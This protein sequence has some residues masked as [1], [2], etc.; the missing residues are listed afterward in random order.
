MGLSAG[1]ARLL[2]ITAR[3]SDCEYQS[4]QFSHQK[5]A[6]SRQL[7]DVSN[8][9]QN[10]L[11]QTKLVYDFYGTG[12]SNTPLS[13]GILMTPS[14]LN[15]YMPNLVTNSSGRVILNN[16]YA[17]AAEAAG[18]PKEG[19]G[20]TPSDTVRNMFLQGLYDAGLITRQRLDK[21]SKTAYNQLAGLGAVSSVTIN[22]QEVS[23]EELTDLLDLQGFVDPLDTVF[24][25]EITRGIGL[26]NGYN[27]LIS[28][29]MS[30][31]DD[32]LFGDAT[33]ENVTLGDI[34]NGNYYLVASG[35]DERNANLIDPGSAV[36]AIANSA[37]WDIMLESFESILDT[38][39][40]YTQDAL[41]YARQ[42]IEFLI[43]NQADPT[44]YTGDKRALLNQINNG[45]V[46]NFVAVTG[47]AD[48]AY[49][50][51]VR[52]KAKNFAD[53]DKDGYIG[54][55]LRFNCGRGSDDDSDISCVSM[56]LSSMMKAY[57]T[58]FTQKMQGLANSPYYVGTQLETS[59]LVDESTLYT[60]NA[61]SQ[62]TEDELKMINFY[63]ALLNQLCTRGWAENEQIDDNTY[64]QEMFQNGM[65]FLT[66]VKDDGF[67]YQG[68]YAT[69][70]YIKTV[71]DETK[72]A[73][74]AAKY[75][76]QKQ[77][78]SSKENSL[79]LKIKNLDTEIS[80]LTTEY[81][82]VK[83]TITK[84]IERTFKRYNA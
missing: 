57:L 21:F 5:L 62:V 49:D 73:Q 30:N 41:A 36:D 37:F 3:K 12:T 63:D 8:E 40:A 25:Q 53:Q 22:T 16:A 38:G 46:T 84:N 43:Q 52:D 60:I 61:S 27:K 54:Y 75:E 6:I 10:S 18:I 64:L 17:Q 51:N 48:Q 80:A 69:D 76:T 81:E 1:Q 70:S 67:Y 24:N 19:L 29:N 13:Y 66:K 28:S 55:C 47:G 7:E 77:R 9:Y 56:N 2:T 58:F 72:I 59:N 44:I 74:A 11:A 20:C 79:D 83:G 68:N 78:L 65:M 71:D 15:E 35:M 42:E 14:E 23:F 50:R 34:L 32:K 82:S 39:D 31:V 4:M 45:V 26:Y 33:E